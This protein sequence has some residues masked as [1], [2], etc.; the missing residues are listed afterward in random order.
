MNI[1]EVEFQYVSDLY[2]RVRHARLES[3]VYRL[4][5]IDWVKAGIAYNVRGITEPSRRVAYFAELYGTLG[6]QNLAKRV[7]D[8]R[9]AVKKYY[10]DLFQIYQDHLL[11]QL[12]IA[13]K[14]SKNSGTE[15]DNLILVPSFK[16]TPEVTN[17]LP[18][19]EVAL[20]HYSCK[21]LDELKRRMS[22]LYAVEGS[23]LFCC[24]ALMFDYG[25]KGVGDGVILEVK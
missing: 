16:K 12:Q 8:I 11:A 5:F 6:T 13:H 14:L 15:P 22:T 17:I 3:E 21:N 7:E 25:V 19:E 2:F 23:P 18:H 10:E 4:E 24:M 20:L 9:T 1:V